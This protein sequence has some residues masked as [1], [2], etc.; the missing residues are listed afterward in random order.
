MSVS[1]DPVVQR[2]CGASPQ[3]DVS[4]AQP[5]EVLPEQRVTVGAMIRTT[6]TQLTRNNVERYVEKLRSVDGHQDVQ[7]RV[8]TA[9]GTVKVDSAEEIVDEDS[10]RYDYF[11]G[12]S[13]D[14]TKYITV[15]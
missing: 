13:I 14:R 4:Q 12:E 5:I 9:I 1:T 10:R 6:E 11:T 3:P 2:A 15:R 7:T 8:I